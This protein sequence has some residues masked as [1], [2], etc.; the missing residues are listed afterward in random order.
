MASNATKIASAIRGYLARQSYREILNSMRE[1][2]RRS[3]GGATTDRRP[4]NEAKSDDG[5][6]L[7][8]VD[9][10]LEIFESKSS[11]E[12]ANSFAKPEPQEFEWVSIGHGRF[13]KK[14]LSMAAE[15][16]DSDYVDL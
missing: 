4:I 1:S 15:T 6:V 7:R 9:V 16:F 14:Q 5:S 3:M 10:N 11:F 12:R 2:I 13:V 8:R